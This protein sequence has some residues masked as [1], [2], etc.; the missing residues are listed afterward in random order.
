MRKNEKYVVELS[1]EER[2]QLDALVRRGKAAARKITRGRILLLADQGP[3][4]PAWLDEDIVEALGCGICTVR[5][6]RKRCVEEGP[7]KAIERRRQRR[8]SN[9]RKLDGVAEAKLIALACGPAP[10]GR[11][12]WTMRLL[13]DELVALEIVDSVSHDTVWRTLKKTRSSRT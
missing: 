7:L 3:L 1:A 4:G 10:A 12:G 2:S 13:A 5:A 11:K 9:L 8:P 6:A